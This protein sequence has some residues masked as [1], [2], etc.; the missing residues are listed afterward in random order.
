MEKEGSST[1]FWPII[2]EVPTQYPWLSQE[3]SCQ[4]LVVG[5]GILGAFSAYQLTNAGVDTVVVTAGPVGY[6]GTSISSGAMY[7]D[8]AF[9]LEKACEFYGA[10]HAVNLYKMR[11]EAID[12][13]EKI[14]AGLKDGC[15]FR[16]TDC[17]SF[18]RESG[19]QEEFHR[20]YLMRRHN[21][22]DVELLGQSQEQELFSFDFASGILSH[23]LAATVDPYRLTHA[24][25]AAAQEKGARIYEHTSAD[26][27]T[28][29]EGLDSGY[30]VACST[31]H[32]ARAE[33]LFLTVGAACEK[34][35]SGCDTRTSFSIASAPVEYFTGWPEKCLIRS[36]GAQ[37]VEFL[38][39]PDNRVFAGGLDS[40]LIHENGK[41]VGVIPLPALEEKK[42]TQLQELTEKMFPGIRGK[43]AQYRFSGRYLKTE[44]GLPVIG[45]VKEYDGA[46]FAVCSEQ[47]GVL[48]SLLAAELLCDLY[49]G[50]TPASL[51]YFDPDR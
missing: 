50:K 47:N 11:A 30:A 51:H 6:G 18:L 44:D 38:V 36:V 21:Q 41:L 8:D 15:G 49:H 28:K 7:Y 39:T 29:E 9:G 13:V 17:L 4:A 27:I 2:Q 1:S 3:E 19:K 34:F 42:F 23:G 12:R 43:Q 40:G 5:G 45:E 24:L 32:T 26:R 35:V 46:F 14:V 25:F 33:R 10:D 48:Y 22:F 31:L 37:G 16:R 20:D